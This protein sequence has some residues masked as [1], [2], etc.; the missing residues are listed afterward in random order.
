MERGSLPRLAWF[1]PLP[2]VH[3]GIARY[4]AEIL[5][6]LTDRFAVEAFVGSSAEEL[7]PPDGVTVRSAHDFVWMHARRPF[8]LVVYQ[9]GNGAAHHYIWGYLTRHPGLVVM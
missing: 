5:P 1:T 8:D 4:S 3:S 6:L 2:P 7:Q 9:L